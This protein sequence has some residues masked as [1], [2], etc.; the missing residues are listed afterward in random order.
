MNAAMTVGAGIAVVG[1][2]LT[3]IF[4]PNRPR[5]AQPEKA[6]QG[7]GTFEDSTVERVELGHE[8]SVTS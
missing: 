4:L 2:V 5:A 3:L 8:E 6:A 1:I 7:S